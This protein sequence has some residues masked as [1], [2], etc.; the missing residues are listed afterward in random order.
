MTNP[1]RRTAMDYLFFLAPI[2]LV[3]GQYLRNSTVTKNDDCLD[4]PA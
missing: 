2:A 3:V 4:C 1:F